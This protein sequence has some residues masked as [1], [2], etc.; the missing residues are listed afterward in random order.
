MIW[1]EL[2][3]SLV[4]LD[5]EANTNTDVLEAVGGELTKQGFGKETYVQALKEREEEF[6]TGLNIDGIGVAIPHTAVDYVD[7]AAIAIATLAKP[8]QFEEMGMPEGC[9]V[10]V[11]LVF[12]LAVT[13]PQGHLKDL[14]RI[15]AILQDKSVLNKVL[16]AKSAAEVIEAI[17][18]KEQT[19]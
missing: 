16:E 1:E 5:L 3:E 4:M 6:P 12:M 15:I 2:S 13:D 17:K 19:L 9:T 10:D 14:Q 7:N 18:E 11:S 8:V